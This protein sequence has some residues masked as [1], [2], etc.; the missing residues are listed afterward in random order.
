MR[1]DYFLIWGNG[2]KHTPRILSMIRD[3]GGFE[4]VR[5]QRVAIDDMAA[6]VRDVYA[7]D[8]APWAHL[9]AKTRYLL[10]APLE[11][12]FALV[13]NKEPDEH[14]KGEG[15]FRHVECRRMTALKK[16][17][18]NR[19]NPRYADQTRQRAPLDPGVS[20]DH[21]IHGSDYEAQTEHMLALLGMEPIAYHR[22][23]DH[24]PYFVPYH[25]DVGAYGEQERRTRALRA[26]VI[27]EGL[28]DVTDT[29]HYRYV[30]GDEA[31]YVAYY[32]R[33]FGTKLCEDHGPAAF[34]RLIVA[35]QPDAV[36][37]DGRKARIIVS[38][39]RI[40]DGVHR[41]AIAAARGVEVVLCLQ[42]S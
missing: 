15:A 32:A 7:T 2:V 6:F 38:G 16:A 8:S 11:A 41:A 9:E 13:V 23:Y 26:N 25:L 1:Y 40:L 14:E 39:D 33:Y 18:R 17:I 42:V 5:V 34:D 30:M 31:A 28:R 19:Y 12:V 35:W 37:W 24:L 10:D 21:C 36:R 4:I 27:G 22:R 3:D 20:H 29:P